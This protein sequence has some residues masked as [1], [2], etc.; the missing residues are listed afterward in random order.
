MSYSGMISRW[1]FAWGWGCG[2]LGSWR[3]KS[4]PSR[5]SIRAFSEEALRGSLR[6]NSQP[7][8]V[9][10]SGNFCNTRKCDKA[11]Q[12]AFLLEKLL[13]DA[14]SLTNKDWARLVPAAA[15]IPAVRVATTFIGSKTSVACYVSLLWN[16]ASQGSK[17]ERYC[18]ARDRERQEVQLE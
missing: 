7:Y 12:S 16:P 18:I 6:Y 9:Q 17:C 5:W 3:G 4:P 11:S 2:G 1:N 13:W 10:Q 15:V 14:K 8:G